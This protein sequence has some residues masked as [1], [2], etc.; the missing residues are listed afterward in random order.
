MLIFFDLLFF[1]L[2]AGSLTNEIYY[3]YTYV[4][5]YIQLL[6]IP[7]IH[8]HMITHALMHNLSKP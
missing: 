3:K 1:N 6:Y 2:K 4:Y 5:I 7:G 8:T